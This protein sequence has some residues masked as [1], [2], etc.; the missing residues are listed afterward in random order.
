MSLRTTVTT[1]AAAF[2]MGGA[3]AA[4]PTAQA[5]ESTPAR[6][7]AVSLESGQAVGFGATPD[8]AGLRAYSDCPSGWICFWSGSNG[9][10]SRCQWSSSL[11]PRAR[12]ECS[13]MNNGTVTKS[14]YN[15]TSYRY[16]YY[17]AFSYQDRIGSTL[18]GGQGNL[19]G[20]YTIGS[21]CRHNA[22]G[23]PNYAGPRLRSPGRG[24][25][26]R[27]RRQVAGSGPG[28]VV[29]PPAPVRAPAVPYRDAH[30]ASGRLK[31]MAGWGSWSTCWV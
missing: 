31:E 19:A 26:E 20:T 2:L 17:R 18:S 7:L 25:G 8:A 9:T 16:H 1:L 30:R 4:A 28:W 15:R 3:L 10:G 27:T 6:P 21:L 29:D 22:S 24:D 14:V 23:C 12:E 11:N 13:W 5:Q